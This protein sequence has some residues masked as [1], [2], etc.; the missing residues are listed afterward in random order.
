MLGSNG[1]LHEGRLIEILTNQF[2]RVQ[3]KQTEDYVTGKFG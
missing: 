2:L 3:K 1:V